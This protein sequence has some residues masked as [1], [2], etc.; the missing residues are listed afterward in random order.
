MRVMHADP[1]ELYLEGDE[2]CYDGQVVDIA[3]RDYEVH[4]LLDIE[5]R[6]V[7]IRPIRRLFRENRIISSIRRRLRSQELLGNF[8]RPAD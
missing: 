8:Y 4:D 7:D 3:Y 6:G 1:A 5:R 2:V